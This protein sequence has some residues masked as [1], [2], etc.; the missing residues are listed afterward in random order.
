MNQDLYMAVVTG[1][2][3]VIAIR[4]LTDNFGTYKKHFADYVTDHRITNLE[5]GH[6]ELSN[7]IVINEANTLR[8]M[9]T[10]GCY[11]GTSSDLDYCSV[12]PTW[13]GTNLRSYQLFQHPGYTG[14]TEYPGIIQQLEQLQ[15]IRSEP[16][17]PSFTQPFTQQQPRLQ[18]YQSYQPAPKV[19]EK[20]VYI[21]KPVE[22]VVE[23]IVEK[24]VEVPVVVEVPA[25][26][27]LDQQGDAI[28]PVVCPKE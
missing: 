15:Q 3:L 5:D 8:N 9:R 10:I 1:I 22:K 20:V 19:V 16:F 7:K 25:E 4:Y 26:K 13:L 6:R 2:L 12:D 27:Q 21:D 17:T 11:G 23:K 18:P 28:E 24:I 14:Q